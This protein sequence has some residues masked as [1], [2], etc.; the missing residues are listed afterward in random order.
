MQ[1]RVEIEDFVVVD[2][3][4][5]VT[6]GT[7][8][9]RAKCLQRLIRLDLPVP[10]TVALPFATVRALVAPAKPIDTSAV[11]WRISVRCTIGVRSSRRRRTPIGGG[12][13]QSSTSA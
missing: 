7:H 8:G 6:A 1:K 5:P 9:G 12:R 13:G 10:L 2:Q 3:T 11:F 4:A